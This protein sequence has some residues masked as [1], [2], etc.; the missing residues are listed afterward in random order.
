[1]VIMAGIVGVVV[2]R[3]GRL[4]NAVLREPTFQVTM[5]VELLENG[6]DLG[7]DEGG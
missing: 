7:M 5:Y 3:S 1:M 2:M 6:L 4:G